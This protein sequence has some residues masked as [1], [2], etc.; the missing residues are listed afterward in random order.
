MCGIAGIIGNRR[1]NPA[2]VR[3]MAGLL[4]HRGPDGEGLWA[5]PDG[6][7]VMAHRRLAVIDT[8]D[9]ASQPMDDGSG[10]RVLCFNGEIY[11]Y[12][13]LALR[14]KAEGASF[15]TTSDSE[16]LLAA[17]AHW[18]E[19]CLN[20][21]NGMFAFAIW[22]GQ[23]GKM[24]CARDRFGEKPFLFAV[25]P[26]AVAF[27]SEYKALLALQGVDAGLDHAR[28]GRFLVTSSE[29]LDDRRET[30]FAGIRQLA[31]GECMGIDLA[32]L[33]V[34]TRLYW[35]LEPKPVQI[36]SEADAFD[37]FRILLTDSVRL[38]MRSDVT[39]GSCLSG[40]L[41]SSAIVCLARKLL[42]DDTPYEVFTGRFPGTSA[43]EW[44]YAEQVVCATAATSHVV[45][46]SPD[47]LLADL[48]DFVWANELPV[49]ST[50]QYAQ[51]C[52]FR[53]AAERGITVLLDGQGAD[54]V[55]AGYE[56][57]F[58]PYLAT[59]RAEGGLEPGE[60][61]AIRARYPAGM[62][63]TATRIKRALP[64]GAKRWL[65]GVTG[66]GSD[67]ALGLA[68]DLLA[69]LAAAK[70]PAGLDPLRAALWRD[71][72]ATHLP[73][74]LRYGD[75]NSMAHSREV[76]LP[77]CDHR[78]AEFAFSL[79]ARLLMGEAQ[80]KRLIR[81]SMA[82]ILPETVRTRWNKQG[83][84]PPQDLWFSHGPLLD[85]ARAVIESRAFAERGLWRAEWWRTV[86]RR[87]EAGESHLAWTLWRPVMTEAWFSHFLD[88]V[89]AQPKMPVFAP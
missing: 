26:G 62:D 72:F 22:D 83:F 45:E 6:H 47:R 69:P 49:G 46:P 18:G 25:L 61:A 7:V 77:F 60:E 71:S 15:T 75:R 50:S 87:L 88:R 74:L 42:G 11:N 12:Q 13:E 82:G 68:P 81:Q 80:T 48:P 76:R 28:L 34:E 37:Q 10:L 39:L 21:L 23:R 70:L 14:L 35:R 67:V 53:L 63:S 51:Y 55:L 17:Y 30:V 32:T 9:A 3:A 19:A 8:S 1:V 40:G 31:P 4:A 58:N 36:L 89:H 20:E 5:S 2:A 73:T 43:D 44:G 52:V 24:F 66:K 27:A 65:S 54:E 29:G 16:V 86:L 84:L 85:H 41:D 64:M 79:P 56:Q 38:R 57:Y 59:R 33:Q 78:L